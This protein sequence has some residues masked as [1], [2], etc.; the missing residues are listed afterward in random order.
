MALGALTPGLKRP[1]REANH[2]PPSNAEVKNKWSYTSTPTYVFM[3]WSLVKHRCNFILL[4]YGLPSYN[5]GCGVK[6]TYVFI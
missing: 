4:G 1:G 6:L 5:S 3:A 2:S